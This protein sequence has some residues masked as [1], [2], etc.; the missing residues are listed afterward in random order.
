MQPR[1]KKE[2]R[3]MP[4]DPKPVHPKKT[5]AGPPPDPDRF[6]G[7]KK[8]SEAEFAERYKKWMDQQ[9]RKKKQLEEEYKKKHA[10]ELPPSPRPASASSTTS[11]QDIAFVNKMYTWAENHK[12]WLE[13]ERNKKRTAEEAALQG[14]FVPQIS[15]ISDQIVIEKKKKASAQCCGKVEERLLRVPKEH[16]KNVAALD[17]K[18]YPKYDKPIVGERARAMKRTG[19]VHER[20]YNQGITEIMKQNLELSKQ[21]QEQLAVPPPKTW[22][23][24]RYHTGDTMPLETSTEATA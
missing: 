2:R 3:R 8:V 19:D 6:R 20:L 22:A 14:M 21:W 5:K 23:I 13:E 7:K 17:K 4:S 15:P 10:D 12:K 16:E 9:T 1:M 11:P 18:Y 24:Q